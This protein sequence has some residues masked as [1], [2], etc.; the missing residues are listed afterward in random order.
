[1]AVLL[2]EC[3]LGAVYIAMF[4]IEP[5][6]TDIYLSQVGQ[7]RTLVGHNPKVW[8]EYVKHHLQMSLTKQSQMGTIQL[9]EKLLNQT[10]QFC[11]QLYSA[12]F[13]MDL[14]TMNR[15]NKHHVQRLSDTLRISSTLSCQQWNL[16]PLRM[17]W[18]F[19]VNKHLD[20][21]LTFFKVDFFYE[22]LDCRLGHLLIITNKKVKRFEFC[23]KYTLFN[24]YPNNPK[25]TIQVQSALCHLA[26]VQGSFVVMDTNVTC[27]TSSAKANS[28]IPP[29]DA[30]ILYKTETTVKFYFIAVEKTALVIVQFHSFCKHSIYDGPDV[31]TGTAKPRKKSFYLLS[32]FQCFMWVEINRTVHTACHVAFR[33]WAH[34]PTVY[35]WHKKASISLPNDACKHTAKMYL[36]S[37]ASYD[38]QL[39]ATLA[40]MFVPTEAKSP[41]CRH[42]GLAVVE[43]STGSYSEITTVCDNESDI[44]QSKNFYSHKS[45][46]TFV[47]FWYN[48]QAPVHVELKL[49]ITECKAVVLE[50][51][52]YNKWKL[53]QTVQTS[54]FKMSSYGTDLFFT[55]RNAECAVLQLQPNKNTSFAVGSSPSCR[56]H[57]RPYSDTSLT[58]RQAGNQVT[59]VV[60]GAI[61]RPHHTPLHSESVFFWGQPFGSKMH[62]NFHFGETPCKVSQPSCFTSSKKENYFEVNFTLTVPFRC[63]IGVT[64]QHD[65]YVQIWSEFVLRAQQYR[66]RQLSLA[67]EGPL[68]QAELMK[69]STLL[70]QVHEYRLLPIWSSSYHFQGK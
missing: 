57:L 52:K 33:Q 21:N 28:N 19:I 62:R 56:R 40:S 3:P 1:M 70:P 43:N 67:L 41:H 15:N 12:I 50:L 5:S 32:T 24:L 26:N 11:S 18:F 30:V 51:C 64:F 9:L 60:T 63:P 31:F 13:H 6:K 17:S 25:V 68:V 14:C 16:S 10:N 8:H 27:T 34:R 48:V 35:L 42:G 55:L 36:I 66:P 2:R 45:A 23:G 47:V 58:W 59:F 44:S 53:R 4:L 46:L 7:I 54:E 49:T 37:V 65:L 20:L 22:N 29:I 69:F 61:K 38:D 39:N